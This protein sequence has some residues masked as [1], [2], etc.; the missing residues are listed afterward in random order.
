MSSAPAVEFEGIEKS[1]AGV[2]V[3]KRVSFHVG[4]GRTLGLVGENGAGK[5]TLM[6][7]LGGNLRPDGGSMRL[8]GGIYQPHHPTDA[9]RAQIAFIHQELNLFPNLSIAE[10]IFLTVLPRGR[11]PWIDRRA[12]RS[13]TAALLQEVGLGL[14][15]DI[16]VERLSAGERQ[17]VEIA[18]AL[19]LDAGLIIFDEPTTSLSARETDALF[20][21]MRRF[22]ARG[23]A[24]IYISH[25]LGDVRQLCH[26]LVVLRDG[27][28]VAQGP[29]DSVSTPA[30]IRAMVGRELAQLYPTRRDAPSA[31]PALEVRHL[32]QPHVI[33]DISFTLHRGEVLGISGLMGA[34][35][36]E[37]ARIVFGL[38]SF[39][40]GEILV[41]G[42]PT[43]RRGPLARI[44]QGIAFVTED[45]RADGLCL[46]A[47]IAD[48]LALASLRRHARSPLRLIERSSWQESITRIRD[49]V[50]LSRDAADAQP[51]TTL[52]GGNQQKVVV[53][54]W[55]LAAPSVLILD[56]PTRGVDVG[57]KH[58]LYALILQL[59]D[60]GTAVLVI[61]SEIEELLGLCDRILVLCRGE[62]RGELSRPE[63]SRER[64]LELALPE[65]ARS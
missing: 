21:L 38:D 44:Q 47:S 19:S 35:R 5:S 2:S 27:A 17:L 63:F 60:R 18:R 57:A 8:H 16:L 61:S 4:A 26:D 7:I 9:A 42:R 29:I 3:L 14:S 39:T 49:A 15:P 1:F 43:D 59:A 46:E 25:V 40:R 33:R 28:V 31:E 34:G 51:V 22:Q 23:V 62:L 52:S 48:N 12:L 32:T 65:A 37:L 11:L 50:R 30:I 54:K 36:S 13:R 55:L 58:E 64:L 20:A 24:M 45:R 6:N 53:G 56:E 41:H 10:N